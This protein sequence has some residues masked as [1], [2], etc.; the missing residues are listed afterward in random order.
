MPVVDTL[1][2][3]VRLDGIAQV[4]RDIDKLEQRL[5]DVARSH[6][7]GV[8]G[9]GGGAA[10]GGG[11]RGGRFDRSFWVGDAL[12]AT[13]ILLR[14]G[15]RLGQMMVAGAKS[16]VKAYE[17]YFAF[18][19]GAKTL[20]GKDAGKRFAIEFQ[21]FAIP[22]IYSTESLRKAGLQMA[23]LQGP[24]KALRTLQNVSDILA[25][26]GTM[27][28][29]K[30]DSVFLALQQIAGK[31]YVAGEEWTRQLANAAPAFVALLVKQAG[32]LEK[33]LGPGGSQ[34]GMKAEQF[35]EL[36]HQ[37]ATEGGFTGAQERLASKSPAI[38]LGQILDLFEAKLI[39]VGEAFARG[40]MGGL[41][42][43]E[44]GIEAIDWA[45]IAKSA[46]EWG[47]KVSEFLKF[48][49]AKLPDVQ[50]WIKN[51]D[52]GGVAENFKRIIN[53][54]AK[55]VDVISGNEGLL[56]AFFALTLA[57]RATV[58]TMGVLRLVVGTIA[59]AGGLPGRISRGIGGFFG[60]MGGGG[61]A[62]AAG[63]AS[64]GVSAT[65]VAAGGAGIWAGIK[66]AGSSAALWGRGVW[67]AAANPGTAVVNG[68]PAY[69][70][71]AT[72][73]WTRVLA[74]PSPGA[75]IAGA[76]T[77]PVGV[78]VSGA[79][80][81]GGIATAAIAAVATFVVSYMATSWVMNK[82]MKSMVGMS[83]EDAV[84]RKM[85]MWSGAKVDE[86]GNEYY[87]ATRMGKKHFEGHAE[88]RAAYLAEQ[89]RKRQIQ[90][91]AAALGFDPAYI[92]D[93][94]RRR[95]AA[96]NKRPVRHDDIRRIIGRT[97]YDMIR[98]VV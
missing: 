52:I 3:Q 2:V 14:A 90:D 89:E 23:G 29:E 22:A 78:G 25:A 68:I 27:D 6:R 24:E 61:A 97:T 74:T 85:A 87:E 70:D 38:R 30:A 37:I 83:Y 76:L 91:V 71:Q 44:A 45:G 32:G 88:K 77:R 79:I 35:F 53:S 34:R 18:E 9:R 4:M 28:R 84:A 80:T 55:I 58:A 10:G 96:D 86:S 12:E 20:L 40:L 69:M 43:L 5:Q 17:S 67:G 46:E 15:E 33:I 81:A 19:L 13:G 26:T 47:K 63:A 51:F 92:E 98:A 65:G 8:T 59:A 62:A 16:A 82:I 39:P 36:I 21:K 94:R 56:V 72:G 95:A 60:G 31:G 93:A 57:V 75:G 41:N 48:L 42:T 64:G 7:M 66:A 50:R 49:T 54:I 1:A 11:G 73:Q